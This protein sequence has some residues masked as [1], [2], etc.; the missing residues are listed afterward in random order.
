MN[1]NNN[2]RP[3]VSFSN[4][5]GNYSGYYVIHEAGI[6]MKTHD[7]KFIL[8]ADYVFSPVNKMFTKK[9]EF[10]LI[11]GAVCSYYKFIT[12]Y[13]M[14]EDLQKKKY[15]YAIFG[16]NFG[17]STEYFIT[18][19]F[20]LKVL[21]NYSLTQSKKIEDISFYY[22]A[23]DKNLTVSNLKVNTSDFNFGV[24]ASFNLI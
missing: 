1:Y 16:A 18:R 3:F 21:A 17:A 2:I 19:R 9:H 22:S 11:A 20:S 14:V 24:G 7:N 23:E 12:I 5:E 4:V 13:N 8:G 6:D 15:N 10:S